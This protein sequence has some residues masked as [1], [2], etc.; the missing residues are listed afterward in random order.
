MQR[1]GQLD[2][3]AGTRLA[4]REQFE[5]VGRQHVASHDCEFARRFFR[6]RLLDHP[7]QL[8]SAIAV[9]SSVDDAVLRDLRCARP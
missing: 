2:F 8:V 1:V 7:A 9:G 4:R 5:N 6:R 3:A